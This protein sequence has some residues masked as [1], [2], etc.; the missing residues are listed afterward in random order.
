MRAK[1]LGWV[2]LWPWTDLSFLTFPFDQ[3]FV[4]GSGF[5][6]L[7]NSSLGKSPKICCSIGNLSTECRRKNSQQQYFWKS[8]KSWTLPWIL[9][10]GVNSGVGSHSAIL[11]GLCQISPS[12][13]SG[14]DWPEGV[15]KHSVYFNTTA[16][17]YQL[18][19][20]G[21]KCHNLP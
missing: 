3:E 17:K 11:W 16:R 7:Q 10:S 1:A 2:A 13:G 6:H 18:Y 12:F 4:D 20:I 9:A 15:I 8:S 19:L 21:E 14:R 5:S